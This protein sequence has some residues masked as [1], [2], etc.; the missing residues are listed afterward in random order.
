MGLILE[1][2]VE[3]SRVYEQFLLCDVS[4][5]VVTILIGLRN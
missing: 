1:D 2:F 5:A 4:I 3:K